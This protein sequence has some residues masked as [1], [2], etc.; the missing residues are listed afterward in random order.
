MDG[1]SQRVCVGGKF[2]NKPSKN[3]GEIF[4]S[5]F[6]WMN[7]PPS[8]NSDIAY[9]V[10]LNVQFILCIKSIDRNE[11]I[12]WCDCLTDFHFIIG[13]INA[14]FPMNLVQH[15]KSLDNNN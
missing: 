1:L 11:S 15:I 5:L 8:I 9:L 3:V 12:E 7:E 2:L 10:K 6:V 14:I 4:E 13:P